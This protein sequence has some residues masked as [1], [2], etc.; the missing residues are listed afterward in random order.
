MLNNHSLSPLYLAILNN[1]IECVLFLLDEGTKAFYD[2]SD[3]ERDRSPVFLAIRMQNVEILRAIF[4][5]VDTEEQLLM[6]TSQG[7]TPVMFA[8]R[9][10]FHTALNS[11]I[12]LNSTSI[13]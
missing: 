8:A 4:E 9:N 7:L 1:Q 13:N 12:E 5:S 10:R 2:G 11:L 6:R 3:E